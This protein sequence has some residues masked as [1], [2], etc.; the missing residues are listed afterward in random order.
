M[1]VTF[2]LDFLNILRAD[3]DGCADPTRTVDADGAGAGRD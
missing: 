3:V 2:D 1:T